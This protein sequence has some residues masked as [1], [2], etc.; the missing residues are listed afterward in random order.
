MNQTDVYF[1]LFQDLFQEVGFEFGKSKSLVKRYL[2]AE[3]ARQLYGKA[4]I[5][6]LF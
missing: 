6:K 2:A 1:N 5:I 3:F 4:I